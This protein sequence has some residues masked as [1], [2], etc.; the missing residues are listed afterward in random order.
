[1]A[2]GCDTETLIRPRRPLGVTAHSPASPQISRG[3]K[4][5]TKT[6]RVGATPVKQMDR[7]RTGC[8]S[9]GFATTQQE[10]SGTEHTWPPRLSSSL[11]FEW[12]CTMLDRRDTYLTS[13]RFSRLTL[14]ASYL[15]GMGSSREGSATLRRFSC[16]CWDQTTKDVRLT[17]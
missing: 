4:D 11:P 7:I 16:G 17:A 8:R 3:C 9:A 2:E 13:W 1:M 12:L 14:P 10:A 15:T 5:E 6:Q